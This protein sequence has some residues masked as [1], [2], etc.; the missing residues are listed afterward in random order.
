MGLRYEVGDDVTVSPPS[1]Q[2]MQGTVE[3]NLPGNNLLVTIEKTGVTR[4]VSE[5]NIVDDT[6]A[7]DA[8]TA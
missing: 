6:D 5:Q 2:T 7:A 4:P 8:A 1:E 3:A